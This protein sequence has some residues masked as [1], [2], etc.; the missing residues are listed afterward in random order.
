MLMVTTFFE[1]FLTRNRNIRTTSI[2]GAR[3]P[4]YSRIFS[5]GMHGDISGRDN[6]QSTVRNDV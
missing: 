3:R 2:V 5:P 6:V 4:N 1:A